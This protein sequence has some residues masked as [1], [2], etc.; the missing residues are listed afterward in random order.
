MRIKCKRS[1]IE[2]RLSQ[3][4]EVIAKDN[5]LLA[6]YIK[7]TQGS[8]SEVG[9]AYKSYLV[10]SKFTEGNEKKV[11]D[12]E[13]Q[14]A[15]ISTTFDPLA[16]DVVQQE[17]QVTTLL[18]KIRCFKNENEK[19]V[20]RVCEL[21]GLICLKIEIM[22][23]AL[24]EAKAIVVVSDLENLETT[25]AQSYLMC[26]HITILESLKRVCDDNLRVL[27]QYFADVFKS[28]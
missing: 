17:G 16:S 1:L 25:E 22:V 24:K 28:L 12:L 7:N 10:L 14:L 20:G 8:I 19:I 9:K 2:K 3:L 11:K 27:K 4:K 23:S 21:R 5:F 26:G 18:D 6:T 13:N 15:T